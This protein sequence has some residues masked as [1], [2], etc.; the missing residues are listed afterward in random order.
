LFRDWVRDVVN[1]Q[2]GVW[3]GGK[4]SSTT[5][6]DAEHPAFAQ[7]MAQFNSQQRCARCGPA[8]EPALSICRRRG[9]SVSDLNN[10]YYQHNAGTFFAD[11]VGVDMTPL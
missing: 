3:E 11:T 8:G 10:D 7:A 1:C 6:Q 9:A 5:F 4:H 2:P